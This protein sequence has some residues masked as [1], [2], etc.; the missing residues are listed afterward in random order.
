MRPLS[1]GETLD[2]AIKLARD[3]IGPL[4][5]IVL[6]V[7]IPIEIVTFLVSSSTSD[8]QDGKAVYTDEGAYIAGQLVNVALRQLATTFVTIGCFHVIAEA[9]LGRDAGAGDSLAFAGRRLPKIIWT[10]LILILLALVL[11]LSV[12]LLFVPLIWFFYASA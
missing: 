3:H 5:L 6:V 11:L 1:I 8:I 4:V 12:V 10:G 2:A 7:T 9:Y